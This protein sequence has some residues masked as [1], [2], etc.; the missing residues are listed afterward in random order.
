M[1][2]YG[3][4]KW[5]LGLAVATAAL[6]CA[7]AAALAVEPSAEGELKS[8]TAV[9]GPCTV[10]NNSTEDE[11]R[12]W[13]VTTVTPRRQR[14][15]KKGVVLSEVPLKQAAEFPQEPATF[16]RSQPEGFGDPKP[17]GGGC[18][19]TALSAVGRIQRR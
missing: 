5:L 17:N 9:S 13:T 3:G 12:Y 11:D 18:E 6:F 1:G 16:Y 14:A 15:R 4:I 7:P 10:A 19:V 8:G 2:R